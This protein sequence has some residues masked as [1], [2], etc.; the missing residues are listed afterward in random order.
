[1]EMRINNPGVM[2]MAKSEMTRVELAGEQMGKAASLVKLICGIV[3]NAAANLMLEAWDHIKHLDLRRRMKNGDNV[4]Y[5]F[6]QALIAYHDYERRLLFT[7]TMR[8]F[9]VAD[10]P[11]ETRKKYGN[12]SDREYYELWTGL[13]AKTYT[14]TRDMVTCLVNKYRILLEQHGIK[15]ALAKAWGMAAMDALMLAHHGF[16][17]AMKTSRE[18]VTA[19]TYERM[20]DNFSCFDLQPVGRLWF[21]A[22][23][24]L[25]GDA[26]VAAI[27]GKNERNLQLSIEQLEDVWMGDEA[28]ANA[29]RMD[30]TS[31]D[32]VWRTKGEMRKALGEVDDFEEDLRK[33]P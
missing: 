24:D 20:V 15:D 19:I 1:M 23:R 7:D 22:M 18:Y 30:I 9:H 25:D 27:E 17:G 2:A 5:E 12:I 33:N 21:Q 31:Y 28:I 8:F 32:E 29:M 6:K 10:M 3:N 26:M 11:A 13:G 14:V 16:E 4:K